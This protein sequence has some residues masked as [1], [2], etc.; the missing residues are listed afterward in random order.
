MVKLAILEEVA[1]LKKPLEAIEEYFSK[2]TDPRKDRTKDYKQLTSS[3]LQY[4][5]SFVEQKAG[6]TSRIM[7]TAS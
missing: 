7:E 3:Q 1:M 6:Q 5:P 4:A 2:V